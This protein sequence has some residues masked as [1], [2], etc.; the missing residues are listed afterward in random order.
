SLLE[1]LRESKLNVIIISN[2]IGLGVVPAF[3]LGRIFR[4]LMGIVNKNIAEVSDEV[5]LFIAGL[6]QRLK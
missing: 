4:D 1:E 2:E 5:Y 3:P 6:K